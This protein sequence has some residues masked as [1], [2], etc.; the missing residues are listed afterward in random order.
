MVSLHESKAF[1]EF[2]LYHGEHGMSV[3]LPDLLSCHDWGYSKAWAL[4]GAGARAE[5]VL[6]HMLGDAVVHYGERWRGQQRKS[7]WAYLRMGLLAR[8]YDEFHTYAEEHGWRE[9]GLPRDSRRGWAHS[10]VE[11]SID[12]WLADRRDLSVMHQQVRASAAAVAADLSW[13]HALVEQ[14]VITP[15]KP[16]ESQPYRYCG[17]LTRAA[18]PDEIHLRGLAVKFHLSEEPAA[19]QWLREW[20]RAVWQQVGDDEMRDVFAS[21]V[22]VSADPVRFGY[23]LEI[24]ALATLPAGDSGRW[25]L[26]QAPADGPAD[27]AD[28]RPDGSAPVADDERMPR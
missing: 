7:G 21:L 18:A 20:L 26:D 3:M 1:P 12:Q 15:S 6:A 28:P 27:P 4:V 8:R 17:A 25:H 9:A 2:D 24:A 5:M 23:P 22:R 13:V 19:L 16:I 11:Y 10:M 14:H